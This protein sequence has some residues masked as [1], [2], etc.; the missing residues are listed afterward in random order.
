M[1]Y[2]CHNSSW[3]SAQINAVLE[4][5]ADI[6]STN[7]NLSL[8][9]L[10]LSQKVLYVTPSLLAATVMWIDI[11]SYV[12]HRIPVMSVSWGTVESRVSW[13]EQIMAVKSVYL[14]TSW[15]VPI[16]TNTFLPMQY[17][18]RSFTVVLLRQVKIS[19]VGDPTVSSPCCYGTVLLKRKS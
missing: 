5:A 2:W 8:L 15:C 18:L 1:A 9:F 13:K 10:H 17:S 16:L 3:I 7:L 4:E 12:E 19:V 14:I 6:K 11:F